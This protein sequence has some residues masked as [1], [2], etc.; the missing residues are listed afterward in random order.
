MVNVTELKEKMAAVNMTA[1]EV[2]TAAGINVSTFYR[3]LKTGN[4]LVKEAQAIV[5]AIGIAPEN[6][7]AI[8][9]AEKVA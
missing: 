7:V 9:F 5:K 3:K 4:F 6:A 8:F 2:A 1:E